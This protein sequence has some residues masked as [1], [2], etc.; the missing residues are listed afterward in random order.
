MTHIIVPF[1]ILKLLMPYIAHPDE[2]WFPYGYITKERF[3]QYDKHYGLTYYARPRLP[4]AYFTK[5]YKFYQDAMNSW[6]KDL[7][8]ENKDY[9]ERQSKFNHRKLFKPVQF[10]G[11]HRIPIYYTYT[12]FKKKANKYALRKRKEIFA[13][14]EINR[15]QALQKRRQIIRDRIERNRQQAIKKRKIIL[16]RKL[17]KY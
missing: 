5:G 13:R 2:P 17:N 9:W 10:M 8:Q 11:E 15:Q 3:P 1:Q 12:E 4:P 6:M 7:E 16:A 14:I